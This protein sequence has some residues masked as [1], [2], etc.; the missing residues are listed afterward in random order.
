MHIKWGN[1]YPIREIF[2]LWISGAEPVSLWSLSFI[3]LSEYSYKSIQ[4][5]IYLGA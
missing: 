5:I 2:L 3:T 1:T 4:L